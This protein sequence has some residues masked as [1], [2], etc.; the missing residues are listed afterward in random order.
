MY[1]LPLNKSFF[2]VPFLLDEKE[3]KD[4]MRCIKYFFTHYDLMKIRCHLYRLRYAAF[5]SDV[6]H[7]SN[8]EDRRVIYYFLDSLEKCLEGAFML[9]LIAK[10]NMQRKKKD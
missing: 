10:E 1:S 5:T 7:F 2:R 4:P 9:D 6:A 8:P 3:M